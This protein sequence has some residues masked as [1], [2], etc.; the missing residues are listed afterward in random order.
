[1]LTNWDSIPF[2]MLNHSLD[3]VAHGFKSTFGGE[4]SALG[5]GA[6]P[7]SV[8]TP[9]FTVHSGTFIDGNFSVAIATFSGL[10]SSCV[11]DLPTQIVVLLTPEDFESIRKKKKVVTDLIKSG[12]DLDRSTKIALKA[13]LAANSNKKKR[14]KFKTSTTTCGRSLQA[15]FE[16][17]NSSCNRWWI[18]VV[19][20]I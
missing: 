13:Q 18:A 9:T 4:R 19:A 5:F 2:E 6:L 3:L 8:E 17:D 20:T 10:G 12:C 15:T 14:E 7:N 1:M 16:L 11:F